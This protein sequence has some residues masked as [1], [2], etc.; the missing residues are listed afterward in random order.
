MALLGFEA[1]GG[2]CGALRDRCPAASFGFDCAGSKARRRVGRVKSRDYGRIVGVELDKH[3]RRSFTLTLW[4][5]PSWRRGYNRRSV[6]ERINS[7]L[8]IRFNVETHCIRG[9]TELKTRVGL[10]PAVM[11][12]LA[13]GQVRAGQAERMR[14]LVAAVRRLDTG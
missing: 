5:S 14:S 6:I 1:E 8:D 9:I 7:R 3:D 13:L 10:A 4:S 11:M 2:G 12:A